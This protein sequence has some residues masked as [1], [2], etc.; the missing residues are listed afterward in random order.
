ME[1]ER[2]KQT[3]SQKIKKL[4]P[5]INSAINFRG[6][7][8]K[9][10]SSMIIMVVILI[11]LLWIIQ[12]ASFGTFFQDLK[13]QEIQRIGE[14]VIGT[15]QNE[16]MT[17]KQL[18]EYVKETALKNEVSIIIFTVNADENKIYIKS[19]G[20]TG[21]MFF[22]NENNQ[23]SPADILNT[24]VSQLA[25]SNTCAY[26]S[27]VNDL[28]TLTYGKRI[29]NNE[30]GKIFFYFNASLEPVQSTISVLRYQ[31]A[32]VS[33]IALCVCF[34]V[35]LILSFNLTK[36]LLELT[37]TANKM[38]KG[39]LTVHFN[40]KG[41]SEVEQLSEA[42]NY[43][44]AELEKTENLRKDVVAN[45]SH[46]LRTPLTMI[47]AYAE[48]IRDIHGDNKEKRENNVQVILDESDR[49]QTLI[50]DF[51]TLSKMQSGITE[52]NKVKINLSTL[53]EKQVNKFKDLF[54]IQG[55]IF[56]VEIEKHIFV[57]ADPARI[58]QV[59]FNLIGNAINYSQ[60]E[61][62]IKVTL[63]EVNN[64]Y[65]L[66]ITD[67]GVGIKKDDLDN[68]FDRYF[69]TEQTKRTKIGSGIGLSLV[70]EILLA[71]SFNFGATSEL[72]KG[73]CFYINFWKMN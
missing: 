43:A 45:V 47:K 8:F 54:E 61:K 58:E 51:L 42:L 20:G 6:I 67:H 11:C 17:S 12:S 62:F 13:K 57:F 7:Q 10:I 3:N 50:D 70:K 18:D 19:A 4:K 39:D 48:L 14:S 65:R 21:A 52:Y 59:V 9:T 55:F 5:H 22:P 26:T 44:T 24:F 46:E 64:E 49:L 68:I 31:L 29:Y 63:K 35:A 16:T 34:I 41:Y 33:V 1:K 30:E 56:D 23:I 36:P 71:H 73:S 32:I 28:T 2:P 25:N 69:R 53:I 40:G 60:D 72:G 38:A 27:E 37:E 66:E 15:Y